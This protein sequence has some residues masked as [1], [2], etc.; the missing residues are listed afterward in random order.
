MPLYDFRC[1]ECDHKFELIVKRDEVPECPEC[2]HKTTEKL[3]SAG[4]FVLQGGGWY[5]D[6]Y[7][8]TKVKK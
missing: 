2:G 1:P 5:K 4:S 8:S 3:I 6:G 7:A